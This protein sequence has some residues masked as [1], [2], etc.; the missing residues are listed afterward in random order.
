MRTRPLTE[1][2]ALEALEAT[3]DQIAMTGSPIRDQVSSPFVVGDSVIVLSQG[4]FRSDRCVIRTLSVGDKLTVIGVDDVMATV[5]DNDGNR[6][7]IGHVYLK[8]NPKGT[9]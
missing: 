1:G 8:H 3:R 6:F 9:R 4:R 5:Q 2:E 7:K